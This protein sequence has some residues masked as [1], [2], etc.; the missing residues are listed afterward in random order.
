MAT[1][2]KETAVIIFSPA[3]AVFLIIMLIVF[4]GFDGSHEIES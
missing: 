1:D 4:G 3:I 2:L